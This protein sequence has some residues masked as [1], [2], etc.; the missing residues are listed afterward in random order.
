MI[1]M[2]PFQVMASLSSS[3]SREKISIPFQPLL[4]QITDCLDFPRATYSVVVVKCSSCVY[5]RTEGQRGIFWFNG[6]DAATIKDSRES[7][8]E[9][10]VHFLVKR[11]DVCV[12]DFT[13]DIMRIYNLCGK[14][15]RL[16][17]NSLESR[18][19][20]KNSSKKIV[21]DVI[22]VVIDYVAFL[23]KVIRHTGVLITGLETVHSEE[24]GYVS[25]L[26]VTST[27]AKC[28][29]ECIFS[30]LCLDSNASR[31]MVA[32]KTIYYLMQLYN[33]DIVDANYGS[34]IF[35]GVLCSLEMESYLEVEERKKGHKDN[36]QLM[37][38]LIE[39]SSSTLHNQNPQTTVIVP[40]PS[41]LGPSV[42]KRP[43]GTSET[44]CTS[45]AETST[46]FVNR[47]DRLEREL[48]AQQPVNKIATTTLMQGA[49]VA[50]VGEDIFYLR[51]LQVGGSS[52]PTEAKVSTCKAGLSKPATHSNS[53]RRKIIE[54]GSQP[55]PVRFII[56]VQGY[57][58]LN[59][60][61]S[62][63]K[64]Y[65][66]VEKSRPKTSSKKGILFQNLLLTDE[67]AALFGEQVE[68]FNEAIVYNGQYII[69]NAPIKLIEEQWRNNSNELPFQMS[70]GGQTVVQRVNSEEIL[71][72]P[73]FQSIKSIPRILMPGAKYDVLGIVLYVEDK[74]RIIN[75]I[76]IK[77]EN[78]IM[79]QPLVI[80]TWNDLA[81]N[82]CDA[83]S[84]YAKTFDVIGF[85]ALRPSVHK[86]FSLFTGMSTEVIYDPKGDKAEILCK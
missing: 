13:M 23:P 22:H 63:S 65:S 56:M 39:E 14:L 16:K 40:G 73:M 1:A 31:Q 29:M 41:T 82:A 38:L 5:I 21:G 9:R 3:S 48:E 7:V 59:E 83:I 44:A 2:W 10:A 50:Q 6:E 52:L 33:L 32:K 46:P 55:Q 43:L 42:C 19:R 57:V 49:D 8:A 30:E 35:K 64:N 47:T 68:S 20:T 26:T 27:Y 24:Q 51:T 79:D 85:T 37:L 45:R 72:G 36:A 67:K 81:D 76:L 71:D 53:R 28:G 4:D 58:Y 80:T 54:I 34:A 84:L 70:F 60:L 74:V 15:Y 77:A 17:R 61:N 11:Y 75:I 25:W 78:A 12:G 18:G 86:G 62:N 69:S 66:V